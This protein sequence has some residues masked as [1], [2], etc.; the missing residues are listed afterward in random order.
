M[1]R[2]ESLEDKTG[3]SVRF[4]L[5]SVPL[6]ILRSRLPGVASWVFFCSN[7]A[8]MLLQVR[9]GP[10]GGF[11][12][13]QLVWKE[14]RWG[15]VFFGVVVIIQLLHHEKVVNRESLFFSPN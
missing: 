9:N 15:V 5:L 4:F 10:R 11:S 14:I 1:E 7:F 13:L 8:S 3:V 2:V 6:Y 12:D